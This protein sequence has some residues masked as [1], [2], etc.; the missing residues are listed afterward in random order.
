MLKQL[1]DGRRI[2]IADVL[3]LDGK[4][5]SVRWMQRPNPAAAEKIL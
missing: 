1:E 4:P 3:G 2:E 5:V